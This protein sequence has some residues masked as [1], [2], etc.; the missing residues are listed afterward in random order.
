VR[1]DR[2]AQ[3][4]ELEG[5]GATL[6]AVDP[7]CH[8]FRRLH[9]LEI[10]PTL[11]QVL[12]AETP[13]FI[14]PDTT[15]P[16][17]EAARAFARAFAELETPMMIGGGRPP[18]DVRPGASLAKVLINPRPEPLAARLAGAPQGRLTLTGELVF[19]EG[20]RYGLRDHDLVFAAADPRDPAVTDLVVICREPARLPGLAA[21]VG[22]YGKYSYLVFPAGHGET[23][24]GNWP[25]SASPLTA[26]LAP[27]P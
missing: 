12:A 19:S 10:E 25:T 7:D 14:L 16:A 24:K 9:P 2:M 1:L 8:L 17:L 11:S 5:P 15:G 18:A 26:R 6:I 3:T 13:L 23:V 4:F 20:R 21:R 27:A 22:H